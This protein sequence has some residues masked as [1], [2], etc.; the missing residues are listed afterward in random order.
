MEV[1]PLSQADLA[2]GF[3]DGDAKRGVALQDQDAHLN[4]SDLAVDLLP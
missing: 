4:L 3:R 1:F 2:H